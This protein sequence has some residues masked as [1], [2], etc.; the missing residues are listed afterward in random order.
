MT[1]NDPVLKIGPEHLRRMQRIVYGERREV[2]KEQL[3]GAAINETFAGLEAFAEK[4]RWS[5]LVER[6]NDSADEYH[7][8]LFDFVIIG[9]EIHAGHKIIRLN[10]S[11]LWMLL[12]PLHSLKAGCVF[13]LNGDVTGGVCRADIDLLEL[14]VTSMPCKN[15][16]VCIST[17]PHGTE[18]QRAYTIT[19]DD[20]RKAVC[21]VAG[22]KHC[23]KVA[24]KCCET[25]QSLL[26]DPEIQ[27]WI[28]SEEFRRG[29]MPVDT[30]MCD[31]IVGWGNFS[32]D[33]LGIPT[34]VCLPYATSKCVT[35]ISPL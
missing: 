34:N 4:N 22:L 11:S 33:S 30:A 18:S 14:L 20:M 15:N 32:E 28:G 9:H 26:H 10:F 12:N 27:A 31:N 5:T 21:L 35:C 13:Q 24:C 19:W 25:V 6:H 16:I 23:G 1:L 2:M 17:I 29:T 7:V 8:P 3:R